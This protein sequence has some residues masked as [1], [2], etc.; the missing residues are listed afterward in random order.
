MD[1]KLKIHAFTVPNS[2]TL[3]MPTGLR[4]DGMQ[5]LP[6]VYLKELNEN[7]LSDLCDEFRL[8]VFKEAGKADPNPP[9][10]K[11]KDHDHTDDD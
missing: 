2:V 7:L 1:L 3:E 4:Q 8:N 6:R 9:K 5:R 10:P 11:E